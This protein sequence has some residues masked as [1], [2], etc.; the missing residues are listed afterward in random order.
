MLQLVGLEETVTVV[1]TDP[2]AE[3]Y[4]THINLNLKSKII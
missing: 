2:Q 4:R 1:A 3:A